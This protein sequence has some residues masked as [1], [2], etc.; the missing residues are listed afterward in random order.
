M[1]TLAHGEETVA[2]ADTAS[3]TSDAVLQRRSG[4][5]TNS[6]TLV[7]IWVRSNL[8]LASVPPTRAGT[9]TRV[10]ASRLSMHSLAR[11]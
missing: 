11:L 8:D 10:D 2:A 9:H 4:A 1:Q 5:V 6:E 3:S 7:P